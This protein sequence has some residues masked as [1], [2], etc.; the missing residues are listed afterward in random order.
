[1]S[2]L[3]DDIVTLLLDGLKIKMSG[4]IHEPYTTLVSGGFANYSNGIVSK[5]WKTEYWELNHD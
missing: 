2:K 4:D 3:I 1:M 5:N